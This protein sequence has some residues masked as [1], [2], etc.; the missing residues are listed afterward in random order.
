MVHYDFSFMKLFFGPT[1]FASKIISKLK[2]QFEYKRWPIQSNMSFSILIETIFELWIRP[3]T[4][5]LQLSTREY[6]K[7]RNTFSMAFMRG[8]NAGIGFPTGVTFR[9]RI[10]SE[11]G[12]Q[13]SKGGGEK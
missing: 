12:T 11:R 10:Q 5:T 7:E 1:F 3:F 9:G 2:T 13:R 4:C 8:V 6:F